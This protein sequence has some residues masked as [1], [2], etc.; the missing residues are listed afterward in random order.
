MPSPVAS[1]SGATKRPIVCRPPVVTKRIAAA[2]SGNPQRS[3]RRICTGPRYTRICAYIGPRVVRCNKP[4][5]RNAGERLFVST[6]HRAYAG[7]RSRNRDI[8][9][10][11]EDEALCSPA[12]PSAGGGVPYAGSSNLRWGAEVHRQGEQSAEGDT[13]RGNLSRRLLVEDQEG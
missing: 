2:A 11:G 5:S 9:A 12:I 1:S 10:L 13:Q 7:R 6:A 3:G 8:G 4:L